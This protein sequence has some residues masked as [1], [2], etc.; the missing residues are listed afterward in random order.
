MSGRT[1]NGGA[2]STGGGGIASVVGGMAAFTI[3]AGGGGATG[4]GGIIWWGIEVVLGTSVAS[5]TGIDGV[6]SLVHSGGGLWQFPIT[7]V[8]GVNLGKNRLCRSVR[9][10][11][12]ST[13]T[14]Y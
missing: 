3:G 7:T 10:P 13:L 9:H 12:L 6:S 2:G 5:V 1:G 8:A 11:E 14:Q 4:A